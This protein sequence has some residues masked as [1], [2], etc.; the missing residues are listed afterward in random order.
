MSRPANSSITFVSTKDRTAWR[1]KH[2]YS[3]SIFIDNEFYRINIYIKKKPL[4]LLL[5]HCLNFNI[6]SLKDK[7][8]LKNQTNLYVFFPNIFF[9]K[10]ATI[11]C[12]FQ[13][14]ANFS[15]EDV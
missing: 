14:K 3:K 4:P 5:K 11:L 12:R 1:R 6:C 13:I 10:I 8:E 9:K 7:T 2:M 15:N